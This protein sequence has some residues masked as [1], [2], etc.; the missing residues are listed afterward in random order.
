MW[1]TGLEF[2]CDAVDRYVR[3]ASTVECYW[4]WI[5]THDGLLEAFPGDDGRYHLA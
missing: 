3:T 2:D 5:R 4:R 1:L